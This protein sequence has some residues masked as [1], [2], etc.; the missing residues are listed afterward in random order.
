MTKDTELY[1]AGFHKWVKTAEL[2]IEFCKQAIRHS[3][4]KI[5]LE[6]RSIQLETE[7]LEAKVLQ[8]NEALDQHERYLQSL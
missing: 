8:L 5:E 7:E 1:I 2:S 6:R 3:E 4:E